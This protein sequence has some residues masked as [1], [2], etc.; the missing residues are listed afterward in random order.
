ME[1]YYHI[2]VSGWDLV[3]E[4]GSFQV[5]KDL[6]GAYWIVLKNPDTEKLTIAIEVS[7][8]EMEDLLRSENP[9]DEAKKIDPGTHRYVN[10]RQ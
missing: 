9:D 5:R 4:G 10:V 1:C 6:Q 3:S 7:S 2:D 8:G